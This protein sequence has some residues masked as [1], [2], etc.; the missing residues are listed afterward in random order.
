[1]NNNTIWHNQTQCAPYQGYTLLLKLLCNTEGWDTIHMQSDGTEYRNGFPEGW[2][3]Q[4]SDCHWHFW[5]FS[6]TKHFFFCWYSYYF[7]AVLTSTV[8]LFIGIAKSSLAECESVQLR[9][10]RGLA[11]FGTLVK[12]K[13]PR[14]K[15]QR[16]SCRHS[17]EKVECKSNRW[18]R[19][20]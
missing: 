3:I 20:G 18:T 14:R 7:D 5:N 10:I 19:S 8:S 12:E 17:G 15:L 9:W 13:A 4:P 16:A 6:D 11:P 1:M 2:R